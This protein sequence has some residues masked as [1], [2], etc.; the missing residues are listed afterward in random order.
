MKKPQYTS[1]G[2]C[3][4]VNLIHRGKDAEH[5]LVQIFTEDDGTWHSEM[6]FSNYWLGDLIHTLQA[7]QSDI[8]RKGINDGKGGQWGKKLQSKDVV[9]KVNQIFSGE[10]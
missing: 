1:K 6:V 9:K 10:H 4:G 3:H 2:N 7:V 5:V 8:Q